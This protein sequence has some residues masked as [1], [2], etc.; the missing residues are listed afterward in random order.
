MHH[1]LPAPRRPTSLQTRGRVGA[2]NPAAHLAAPHYLHERA[3]SAPRMV[4][5]STPRTIR[6]STPDDSPSWRRRSFRGLC[7]WDQPAMTF[8]F[9]IVLRMRSIISSPGPP[10]RARSRHR[11]ARSRHARHHA[12]REVRC[13]IASAPPENPL[14][15]SASPS[16]SASLRAAQLERSDEQPGRDQAREQRNPNHDERPYRKTRSAA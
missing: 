7:P 1:H 8:G 16:C 3:A 11:R 12:C 5:R 9:E 13:R 2:R 4:R 15:R 14:A 6:R 10:R